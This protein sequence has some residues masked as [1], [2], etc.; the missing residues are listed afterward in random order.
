M[1]QRKTRNLRGVTKKIGKGEIYPPAM[2]RINLLAISENALK[3]R[4]P[5]R[6]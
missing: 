2:E 3:G 6:V 5:V 4:V 1:L